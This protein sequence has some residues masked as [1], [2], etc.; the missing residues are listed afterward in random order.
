MAFFSQI[1]Y[2]GIRDFQSLQLVKSRE[3]G[4]EPTRFLVEDIVVG[5]V[6]LLDRI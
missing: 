6:S 5:E 1:F 4:V 3:R 2:A